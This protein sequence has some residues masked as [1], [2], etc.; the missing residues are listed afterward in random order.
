MGLFLS[1]ISSFVPFPSILAE[2]SGCPG[3]PGFEL[4]GFDCESESG[5]YQ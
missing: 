5:C 2:Q 4:S 1:S 3:H